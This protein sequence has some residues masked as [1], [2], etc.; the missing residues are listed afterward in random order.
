MR[1]IILDQELVDDSWVYLDD[2]QAVEDGAD[3]VVSLTRFLR[4][5][6]QL[7]AHD[8]EVGVRIDAGESLNEII[9]F[10]DRLPLICVHFPAFHDGRGLST[11][12][13]LRERH[14]YAGQIRAVG[15]VMRDQVH[16][17]HRCG[18]NAFDIK[19][20]KSIADALIAFSDFSTG[21]QADV[22]EQR[23]IYRR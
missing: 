15:D 7:L 12:R 20:G 3:V 1:K 10:L 23:P 2:T 22:Y 8:G 17:M 16:G 5:T 18:I 9:P 19:E 14:R 11:A 4:D 21:Y 13:A 6:E